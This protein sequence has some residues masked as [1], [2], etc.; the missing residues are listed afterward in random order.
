MPIVLILLSQ[1][2]GI[3]TAYKF[4]FQSALLQ[5]LEAALVQTNYKFVVRGHFGRK[6]KY[7]YQTYTTIISSLLTEKKPESTSSIIYM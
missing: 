7:K 2:K 1:E 6:N 3:D 5:P 4:F